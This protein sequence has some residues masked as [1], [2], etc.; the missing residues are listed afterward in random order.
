[1]TDW[2]KSILICTVGGAPSVVTETVWAL[3]ERRPQWVP[4]AIYLVTTSVGANACAATLKGPNSQLAALYKL[5]GKPP[6]EPEI[7][8]PKDENGSPIRDIR[9]QSENVAFAN[10][11]TQLIKDHTEGDASTRLHISIAGGRKTMSSY[12][13]AAISIFGRNQ[14]ELTHVL[15]DPPEFEYCREFFWPGQTPKNVMVSVKDAKTGK[16]HT[17]QRSAQEAQ[18]T[19]VPSPFIRMGFILS[20]DAF[21]GGKVEYEKVIEQVQLGLEEDRLILH[22][23]SNELQL[24]GNYRIALPPQPFAF[25]RL[26]ASVRKERWKGLGPDGVGEQY[27]GWLSYSSFLETGDASALSLFEKFYLQSAAVADSDDQLNRAQS[28]AQ[29]SLEVMRRSARSSNAQELLTDTFKRIKN[30]VNSHM[31]KKIPNIVKRKYAQ[32][33]FYQS[34]ETIAGGNNKVKIACFGLFPEPNQIQIKEGA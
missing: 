13:Q 4:D 2:K 33:G 16:I 26:L 6:L 29:K 11:I 19:L 25:Y 32:I 3:L 22:C 15:V 14:D 34:H 27:E 30:T 10:C 20:E 21:P 9:T 1:M 28:K 5:H 18:V 8:V 24:G 17:E 31:E 7:I 12:A 23:N